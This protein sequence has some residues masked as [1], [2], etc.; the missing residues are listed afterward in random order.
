[1]TLRPVALCIDTND[2][3]RLAHFWAG[4]LRPG[5][6]RRP[7]RRHRAPAERRDRSPDRVPDGRG[8]QD[9]PEP[10][11]LRPDE[12][13]PR[14]PAG[15]GGPGPRSRR[16]AHRRRAAAGRGARG[17]RRPRGQRVLRDRAGQ[18]ASSPTAAS[19]GRSPATARRGRLLLERGARLAAGVGPGRGDRDPVAA[20]R[21]QDH[22]GWSAAGAEDR[23]EPA[24]PRP[25]A[26]GR[27]AISRRRSTVWSPSGRSGSTSVRATSAGR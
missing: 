13:V 15:D 22:L 23:E 25:R 1:M 14:G 9:R 11:A 4:V 18:H 7:G 8:A 2:H 21:P 20:G 26:A 12:H 10:D 24:A 3:A 5:D 16:P 27:R 19:S 17:A 6:V